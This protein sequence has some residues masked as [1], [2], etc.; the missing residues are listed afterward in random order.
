MMAGRGKV[1]WREGRS[2][3]RHPADRVHLWALAWLQTAPPFAEAGAHHWPC[4]CHTDAGDSSETRVHIV[5]EG[6]QTVL[7]VPPV[8]GRMVLFLSGAVDHAVLPA[9]AERVALTAWMQ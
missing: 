6:D 9:F 8:S 7:D 5:N 2:L 4:C 1:G 3:H